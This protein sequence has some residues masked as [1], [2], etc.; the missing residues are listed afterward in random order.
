MRASVQ[1]KVSAKALLHFIHQSLAGGKGFRHHDLTEVRLSNSAN[2]TLTMVP[3][4]A[5]KF[6]ESGRV[7]PTLAACLLIPI[8]N[9]AMPLRPVV[10]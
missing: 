1:T 9:K 10:S 6:I 8:R 7:K 5:T 2:S 4:T 3:E